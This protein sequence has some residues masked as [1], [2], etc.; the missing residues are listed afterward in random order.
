[1]ATWGAFAVFGGNSVGG[2]GKG[3]GSGGGGGTGGRG[4]GKVGEEEEEEM[5][6]VAV[7]EEG[8][9]KEGGD[10]AS[11]SGSIDAGGRTGF[12]PASASAPH[13]LLARSQSLPVWGASEVRL[14]HRAAAAKGGFVTCCNGKVL[15]YD[16]RVI[17]AMA[18]AT[19]TANTSS[20]ATTTSA[21]SALST[22]PV[23][24]TEIRRER[25]TRRKEA[26]AAR[27]TGG[28]SH[29]GDNH[30]DD[31]FLPLPPPRF[32]PLPLVAQLSAL[33]GARDM[34]T[35]ACRER[36]DPLYGVEDDV[37]NMTQEHRCALE[38]LLVRSPIG[39]CLAVVAWRQEG[40]EPEEPEEDEEEFWGGGR[41]HRKQKGPQK[42]WV[43]REDHD[44]GDE[45][46]QV[47]KAPY[48]SV[49][50]EAS[51]RV[52]IDEVD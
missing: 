41:G 1:V 9:T 38:D 45:N 17:A 19:A 24:S 23:E 35:S 7:D 8:G 21:V 47:E 25:A 33:L 2:G 3:N 12:G 20:S 4:E 13:D 18:T 22:T 48:L 51:F 34:E 36:Y 16:P 37:R 29:R 27:L 11:N 39:P 46:G 50:R 30:S 44:G 28:G 40:E 14:A 43:G 49:P 5:T 42:K 15:V 52:V 10:S 6:V 26:E 31:S 32:L